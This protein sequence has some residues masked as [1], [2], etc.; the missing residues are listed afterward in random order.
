MKTVIGI[1]TSCYT[2]SVAVVS[3]SGEIL[4]SCRQLLPVREGERGLRQSEAVFAHTRHLA[5]L[6]EEAMRKARAICEATGSPLEIS[7]VA[8]SRTP[9]DGEDSYMPVFQVGCGHAAT[10]AAAL[11]VPCFFTT[12]QRGHIRAAMKD[13]GVAEGPLICLHLSGGT[14]EMLSLLEDKLTLLGGSADLHAGQLVDRV[15]V[16]LGLMFP[17]GPALEKLAVQGHSAALLPVS[18]EKKDL[19]CHLSGAETRL[20]QWIREGTVSGEDLAAEI[21]DFL[22]RTVARLVLGGSRETGI[23]QALLAGGVAS[24]ELFR[25][26]VSARIRKADPKF[27][28]CFGRPELSGDNAVGAALLGADLLRNQEGFS[29]SGSPQDHENGANGRLVECLGKEQQAR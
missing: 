27:R 24:S 14:T 11:D 7:A 15:G 26:L 28:V 3:L 23:R 20:Q 12:H 10:L 25:R 21:Y 5:P 16:A 2:T 29:A 17:A 6:A 13:S 1:D 19:V 4:A 9:R 18:M 22:A 8:V